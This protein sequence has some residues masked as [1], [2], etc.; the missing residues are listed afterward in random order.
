MKV[1]KIAVLA[2]ASALAVST[3]SFGSSNAPINLVWEGKNVQFDVPPQIIDGRQMVP[4][5]KLMETLGYEVSWNS[6]TQTAIWGSTSVAVTT[7]KRMEN[8]SIINLSP[9]RL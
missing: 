2:V 4:M 5:R 3:V 1:S 6:G 7:R 9:K 8:Y